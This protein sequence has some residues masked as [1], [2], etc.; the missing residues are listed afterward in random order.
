MSNNGAYSDGPSGD[1]FL[2]GCA[3]IVIAVIIGT[4]S[5]GFVKLMESDGNRMKQ[6]FAECKEKTVDI[7]WCYK[8]IYNINVK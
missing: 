4:L 5:Y 2:I 1:A 7:E 3:V 8:T 6:E